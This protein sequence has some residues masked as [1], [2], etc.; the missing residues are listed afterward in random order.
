MRG[1][2]GQASARLAPGQLGTVM[3]I[4]LASLLLALGSAGAHA[5]CLATAAAG[6]PEV[7]AGTSVT[8]PEGG[9]LEASAPFTIGWQRPSF[10]DRFP[11]Y[12]MVAFDQPVRFSG[13]GYYGL[14]PG[15]EAPFQI[16]AFAGQTRAVIPLYGRGV[17][18]EGAFAVRPLRAGRLTVSWR[19]VGSDTCNEIAT[20]AGGGSRS[21]DVEAVGT[22]RIVVADTFSLQQPGERVVSPDGATLMEIYDGRYRLLE[23]SGGGQIAEGAGQHPRYS[24]TGRFLAVLSD[25]GMDV[26]D[27]VDGAVAARTRAGDTAW[28][29]RDSF[30]VIGSDGNGYLN[31]VPSAVEGA[32]P[33]LY[34]GACRIC[35][36]SAVTAVRIDL[37]NNFIVAGAEGN[38]TAI[39]LT[40]PDIALTGPAAVIPPFVKRQ[41]GVT[42]FALP[43]VWQMRGGLVFTHILAM[44]SIPGMIERPI[45]DDP[46]SPFLTRPQRLDAAEA[47][48]RHTV[49]DTSAWRGL[50]RLA[51]AGNARIGR[52]LA[53]FGLAL[54]EPA[55]P[56]RAI[57]NAPESDSRAADAAVARDIQND[58]P[59]ARGAFDEGENWGCF[60]SGDYKLLARFSKAWRF[61]VAGEI[62]WLTHLECAEGS[63]RFF[64]PTLALLNG[65]L[66]GGVAMPFRLEDPSTDVGTECFAGIDFCSLEAA[67]YGERYL[68]LW[69]AQSRGAA[70]FDLGTQTQVFKRFNLPRGDLLERVALTEDLATVVQINRD[71]SFST[72]RLADGAPGVEGLYVD[73][74]IVVWTP[75]GRF[76]ATPE[77][78]HFVSLQLPGRPT[79]YTFEQFDAQ[80]R[81]PGLLQQAEA[82]AAPPRLHAPPSL[83]ADLQPGGGHIAGT[84]RAE[85]SAPLAALFVFQ[86]G[87]LTDRLPAAGGD[88]T[89]DVPL[90]PGAR[91]VSLV[92]T[93]T[94]GLASQPMGLDI[95]AAAAPRRVHVV[96]LGVDNYDDAGIADLGFGVS[97][98]RRFA[99]ALGSEAAGLDIASL[100]MLPESATPAEMRQ[101]LAGAT[102]AVQPGDTTVLFFAG[103]GFRDEAGRYYLVTAGTR[104]DDIAG[105]ALAWDEVADILR[106]AKGRV[107]VF[108][109]TC[110]S[111]ASESILASNDSPAASLLERLPSGMVIVSA[112]KGRE[113]SE[114]S[115]DAGGGLFTSALV[116][117]IAGERAAADRNG[118]GAIEISELYRGVKARV[119]EGTAGRQTPWFMRNQLVGDFALF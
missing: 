88:W 116:Q 5:A 63:A 54:A 12:I 37:E 73:D 38:F 29:N 107:A 66:D 7:A 59:A 115:S 117:V 71:G 44:R 4:I 3:R 76:D 119:V 83:T 40:L 16:S 103:H 67:V 61:T 57:V 68:V 45:G 77:G 74:E 26:I 48:T 58:I 85:G 102:A 87:L 21:F 106:Q 51:D 62:Y 31:V 111:G 81:T 47:A 34:L 60:P 100:H 78:A 72:Y 14:L 113:L 36:A 90:L 39:S 94:D 110:H 114:E 50:A 41:S 25:D 56:D 30:I 33:F 118:N 42:D 18:S 101:A 99:E 97:D 109:D 79:P 70:V 10:R 91:W 27:T 112:S 2:H 92:A 32:T 15:A 11:V 96:A 46:L 43:T 52:R 28:D 86:D 35:A 65:A 104:L 1:A 17:P 105:T 80:L 98:A 22:P 93:D 64:Y 75:D 24:P 69:S 108:L 53:D 95:G 6:I 89:I 82:G 55:T 84:A 20:E 23:A 49:A 13:E 8:V 19:V 9:T